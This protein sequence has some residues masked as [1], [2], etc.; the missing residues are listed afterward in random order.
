MIERIAAKEILKNRLNAGRSGNLYFWRDNTGHE[1][2]IIS[3]NDGQLF[4]VE[5][6]SGKTITP[7]YFKGL[8]FWQKI[9]GQTQGSVIYG[10]DQSQK[11]SD[12]NHIY[13]WKN[14]PKKC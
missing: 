9:S 14:I 12:G 2:D 11:R 6:K 4:P 8:A 1:I 7:D 13:S 10:G 5:I 3:E